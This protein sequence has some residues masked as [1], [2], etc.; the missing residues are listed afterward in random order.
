[1]IDNAI[2]YAP[3]HTK[4]TVSAGY[5]T[6]NNSHGVEIIVADEGPGIPPELHAQVFIPYMRGDNAA[7]V[8]GAGLG[9]YLVR[10]ISELHGGRAD[11]LPTLGGAV[12]RIWLPTEMDGVP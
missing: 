5:S 1:L 10:R 9:L 7:Y 3:L 6:E 8:A 11:L 12:F 4:V 2:K